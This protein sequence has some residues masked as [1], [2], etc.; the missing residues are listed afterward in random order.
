MRMMKLG[1]TGLKVSEVGFGGI[2]I[3]RLGHEQAVEVVKGSLDLGV[4]FIDTARGYSTSENRIG[5][6]VASR[7]Q[8]VVVASKTLAR[9]GSEAQADL[10]TSLSRLA[11]DYI[12]IYQLHNVSSESRW[13]EVTVPGGPLDVLRKAQR[14]GVIRHLGA[15]S[16]QADLAKKMVRSGYFE[17][18]MFPFNFVACEPAL[19]VLEV[20]RSEGVAFLAMKPMGGGVLSNARLAFQYLRQFPEVIP[21]VGIERIEEMAEIV[22]L[23]DSPPALTLADRREIDQIV[24]ELGTVFCR[25]CDYCQPCPAGIPI[26]T[27]MSLPALFRRFPEE[28]IFGGGGAGGCIETVADCQ[29]CGDCESRCPYNL[30]IRKRVAEI[31]LMYEESREEYLRSNRVD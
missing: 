18:L 29:D 22:S 25:R 17:T 10:D 23:C 30:T 6:A 15:T 26:S 3:Q 14:E 9:T 13:L 4:N 19:D 2:P 21:V 24:H 12:D 7:R 5:A 31:V 28:H 1:S 11:V 8:H 20:C 27:V 16:H